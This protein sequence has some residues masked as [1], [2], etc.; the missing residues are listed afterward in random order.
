MFDL[1]SHILPGIDDGSANLEMTKKMLQE[2][3]RQGIR[4]V[5]AT[6]HFYA[7]RDFPEAFLQRRD[8][9]MQQVSNLEGNYPKIIVGAEIAY[10]DGISRSGILHKMQL[11]KTGLVLIEMPFCPWTGRMVRE[12]CQIRQ[13]TGLI[14]VL[15]HIDRYVRQIKEYMPMLQDSGVLFQCNADAFLTVLRRRWALRLLCQGSIHFLGTDA[16]NL[17]TRPP[18]LRDACQVIEKKLGDDALDML[19][20][21]AKNWLSL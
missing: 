1:H 15:A 5:A 21:S 8:A 19:H 12:I 10:F 6:P 18:K 7:N 17:T 4:C 13:E 9:A 11:G 16:H 3:H 14:P 2:M 20:V